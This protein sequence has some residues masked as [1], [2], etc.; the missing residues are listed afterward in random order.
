MKIGEWKNF[1]PY[2][3]GVSVTQSEAE[4]Y[5]GNNLAIVVCD[6]NANIRR[7]I[8]RTTGLTDIDLGIIKY[9]PY[10]NTLIITYQN[11]TIDLYRNENDVTSLN[12]IKVNNNIV[13]KKGINHIFLKNEK[14]ALLS[15]DFGLLFMDIEN[16]EFS[17]SVFTPFPVYN[18]CVQNDTIYV[19]TEGGIFLIPPKINIQDF[20]QWQYLNA[21]NNKPYKSTA[22]AFYN[23]D[24]Y[25]GLNDALVKQNEDKSFTTLGT[26]K[27]N[28]VNYLTAEGKHLIC[29]LFCTA[30]GGCTGKI[31][32]VDDTNQITEHAGQSCFLRPLYAVEDAANRVWIADEWDHYKYYDIDSDNC[33]Y[34]TIN[35]PNTETNFDILIANNKTYVT[36]GGL[37]LGQNYSFNGSGMNIYDHATKQWSVLNGDTYP[38]L[39]QKEANFDFLNVVSDPVSPEK[40]FIGSY[41]G[42]LIE[43]NG[44]GISIFNDQ[45]SALSGGVGDALRERVAGLAYDS[46]GNLWMANTLAANP[47]VV[48]KKDGTWKSFPVNTN[49]ALLQLAIDKNDNKWFIIGGQSGSIYVFNEGNDMNSTLDDK[50]REINNSNS[51]LPSN[52]I[53]TV[54]VDNRGDVWIGTAA[55]TVVFE[56]GGDIFNAAQ[57]GTRPIVEQDGFGAYLLETENVKTIKSDGGN[58]KWFGTDNGVF[59]QSADAKTLVYKFD[60]KNSPL[61]SNSITS[62][63]INP[64]NGECW[65]GTSKGLAVYRME[66]TVG[67]P[68]HKSEVYA[69]P[70]PV[71]PDY[72]G[73]I[74]ITGLAVDSD[75]KITDTNGKLVYQTNSIGGQAVWDGNDYNGRRANTGVYLVFATGTSDPENP[76]GLVTKILFFN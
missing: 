54:S 74:I 29:G 20:G 70:N 46:K 30:N 44:N 9:T 57:K 4:V 55:G 2:R 43:Y 33:N 37:I 53:N 15:T 11:G 73:N 40:L 7:Y 63:A 6:K 75:V 31:L 12:Y 58:R 23:G 61:P 48:K 50:W 52:L 62:M 39:K 45:N 51:N 36:A 71:R 47:I 66:S 24:L 5:Y 25:F 27:D 67:G 26:Y 14:T 21:N 64:D 8:T 32:V 34:F 56:Y 22:C 16:E 72:A 68:T 28:R 10:K 69:F 35:S 41:Y 42:G 13:G 19:A 59:V 1:Y 76:N 38:E 60:T 17:E 65:I 3:T 49:N 18:T